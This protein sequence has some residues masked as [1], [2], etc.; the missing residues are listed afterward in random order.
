[1]IKTVLFDYGGVLSE[2]GGK[3]NVNQTIADYY[4]IE[5]GDVQ[6][7]DIHDRLRRGAISTDDFFAEL[8]RRH[9]NQNY[10]TEQI[11]LGLQTSLLEPSKKVYKLAAKLR[12]AG[13][14]TG[15]LSN[16]FEMS[17]REIRKTGGYDGFSPLILSCDVKMA[18]PD[19]EIYELAIKKS[20]VE[21]QEIIFIDDQEKCWPPA[22]KLGMFVVRAISP[23]Q[24]VRDTEALIKRENGIDLSIAA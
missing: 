7:S 14:G 24:I 22:E 20:G 10:L 18:K 6:L 13:I 17:E 19:P 11:F 9:S 23:E 3:S 15:I 4:G 1:M 2:S 12:G 5:I 16:I 8:N 21:P